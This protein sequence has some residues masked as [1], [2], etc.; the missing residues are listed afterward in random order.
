MSL[1]TSCPS[2]GTVFKV[3]ED[4]LKISEGW[5]RCGHC[6]DVFNALEGLFDLDRRD[7]TM[8]DLRTP[9]GMLEGQGY[10]GKDPGVRSPTGTPGSEEAQASLAPPALQTTSWPP[11][12]VKALAAAP[13]STGTLQVRPTEPVPEKERSLPDQAALP[14]AEATPLT[15]LLPSVTAV[16]ES[17]RMS[18]ES[19]V[20][21]GAALPADESRPAPV[22]KSSQ[23]AAATPRPE[24]QPDWLPEEPVA[25]TSVSV[26]SADDEELPTFVREAH[27]QA[28]WSSGPMRASLSA[29]AL[30]LAATLGL[31]VVL[32]HRDRLAATC[33]SCRD[34]L[35]KLSGMLGLKVAS[36]IVVDAVEVDNAV[37]AQP[38]GV[39]GF[40]LTVQV[41]NLA[42]HVVASP[43]MELGL[44]DATGHLLV[45]R[46][47]SPADFGQSPDLPS[48]AE[49]SWTLEFQSTDRRVSGY[50]VAAFHP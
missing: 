29:M 7:S 44:T 18:A 8:Q 36:P 23:A 34:P 35:S 11:P 4:Q 13:E 14:T 9:S 50:T 43:H 6:H 22:D 45:R 12:E 47:F 17:A 1:A 38:P 32:Q 5:V 2:C 28:R 24:P 31:Q 26:A 15:A 20:N 10:P 25:A 30:V 21:A 42:E 48:R 41:R 40:R 46:V 37:L 16:D 27:R 49:Q 33:D 19:I 39:D 3:V